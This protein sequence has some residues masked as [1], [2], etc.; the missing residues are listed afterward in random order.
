[1]QLRAVQQCP[2]V[3]SLWI[4]ALRAPLV[5]F[6]PPR[7]LSDCL[8]LMGEKET[9]LRHEPPEGLALAAEVSVA[10]RAPPPLPPPTAT[11]PPKPSGASS[12][13]SASESSSEEG[14][15]GSSSSAS[16][17]EEEGERP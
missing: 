15:G 7:Q 14:G 9:R 4:E 13:C 1:M 17:S 10:T 16:E 12:G 3:K 2:G 6:V 5:S 8:H 11:L